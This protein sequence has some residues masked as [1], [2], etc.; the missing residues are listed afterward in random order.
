MKEVKHS[1][2][3]PIGKSKRISVL[4]MTKEIWSFVPNPDAK[5]ILDINVS[6][7]FVNGKE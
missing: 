1:F 5:L 7:I 2:I 3:I 4:D 6:E